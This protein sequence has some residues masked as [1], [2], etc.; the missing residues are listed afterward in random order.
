MTFNHIKEHK[1]LT[2]NRILPK[3]CDPCLEVK[4][5]EEN[6][7]VLTAALVRLN[8]VRSLNNLSSVFLN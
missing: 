5:L 2:D 3:Y 8:T 6:W 7:P 1:G 4:N